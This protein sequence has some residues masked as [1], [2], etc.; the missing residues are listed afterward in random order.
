MCQ[1][2]LFVTQVPMLAGGDEVN[3]R[4]WATSRM[5]QGKQLPKL[6][7]GIAEQ[8]RR[9]STTVAEA[10]MA[11]FPTLRVLRTD[12]LFLKK[13]GAVR[14]ASGRKF[15]YADDDHLSDKGVEETKALFHQAISEVL[16]PR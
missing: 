14:Y 8:E 9:T 3:F 13:D 7:T 5:G 11:E 12:Q 10:L 15:F 6:G 16:P 4:E 1:R 2:V